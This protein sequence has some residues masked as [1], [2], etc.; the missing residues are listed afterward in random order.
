M[1]QNISPTL[2]PP[3]PAPHA[4][5]LQA[6]HAVDARRWLFA[7]DLML[8]LAGT[9]V[10]ISLR[11]VLGRPEH[12][13]L[14]EQFS[15]RSLMALFDALLIFRLGSTGQYD[16]GTRFGRVEDTM[17]VLRASLVAASMAVFIAIVTKGFL[18]TGF[19]NYSRLYIG[20]EFVV[21]ILL[22]LIGRYVGYA[23]ELR[24]FAAGQYLTSSLVVGNGAR[25]T[26]FVT[27]LAAQPRLGI[28][29]HQSAVGTDDP[30]EFE[31]QLGA[32]IE[33]L[34][35]DE[36]VLAFDAPR[37]EL[38][39][40]VVREASLR[41]VAVKVLPGVFESFQSE[42]FR[43]G[44][45]PVTTIFELP[46][47]KFSRSLKKFFD[48]V[49]AGLGLIALSPFLVLITALIRME[50]SGPALYR[51]PRVGLHGRS[52]RFW[53]FRTMVP[54]GDEVLAQYLA[55]HPEDQEQWNTFQKLPNDPR[56]TRVG[57]FLRK[58]SLDE[59]PQLINVLFGEMSLVGPRPPMVDQ[60]RAYGE[61]F[62]FGHVRPG[63][64]G[65][66]QVA[67]RNE[68]DFEGRIG[69]DVFY[70]ENWS[71]W[72]DVTILFKTIRVVLARR[73]AY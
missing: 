41:G 13:P 46:R 40:A 15:N 44:G 31:A 34:R 23:M 4:R 39:H 17:T 42:Y 48:Q 43:Y 67:G 7:S 38:Q 20:T 66:W 54:N 57:R 3:P 62:V 24:A 12:A 71:F 22:V 47:R 18:V 70:V 49:C 51:Q 32:E 63:I 29:C 65:L 64:T 19:T 5:D 25:A 33:R 35:P 8:V 68:I 11:H 27:S 72:L 53:K 2:L 60:T 56:V 50:G 6:V 26:G 1:T 10:V 61:R 16:A 30:A 37:P 14:A 59:L 58:W 45:V 9:L 55:E 36:V 73:G 69:L 52:F 28:A 21:P